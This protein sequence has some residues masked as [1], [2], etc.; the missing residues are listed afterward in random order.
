M[1]GFD[2]MC[3]DNVYVSNLTLNA[4]RKGYVL[5]LNYKV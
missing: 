5:W 4:I 2:V 1:L 3:T